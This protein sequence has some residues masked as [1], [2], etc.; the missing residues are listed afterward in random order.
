LVSLE[1]QVWILVDKE[2]SFNLKANQIE[3]RFMGLRAEA[4]I[5][6]IIGAGD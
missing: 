6:G 1:I 3:R 5:F 4:K 2:Q